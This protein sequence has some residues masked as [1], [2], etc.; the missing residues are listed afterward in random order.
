MLDINYLDYSED[1]FAEVIED[2]PA[3]IYVFSDYNNKLQAEKIY[4]NPALKPGSQF[5]TMIELKEKLF[6]TDRLVLKEEKLS[7]IFYELLTAQEKEILSVDDYFD[8]IDLAGDFFHFYD[9]L[10]EYNVEDIKGLKKWQLKKYEIF[11]GLRQRYIKY[12]EKKGFS[13]R[14]LNFCMKNFNPYYLDNYEEVVFVNIVNF[15]PAEKQMLVAVE[16]SGKVVRLYLQLSP[17]DFD[18]QELRVKSVTLPDELNNIEIL[19]TSEKLLQL[20][21]VLA[22][23][24]GEQSCILDADFAQSSYQR[25]LSSSEMEVSTET[26]FTQTTIFKFLNYHYLLL[27]NAE[28]TEGRLKLRMEDLIKFCSRKEFRN[29]Y[30]IEKEEFTRLLQLAAEDYVYFDKSLADRGLKNIVLLLGEV[31]KI[32]GLKSLSDFCTYLENLNF[33]ILNDRK[34]KDNIVQ[35]FDALAELKALDDMQLVSS[36]VNYFS[37]RA[38]GFFQLIINYLKYKKVKKVTDEERKMIKIEDLNCAAHRKHDR[39][40]I[41]NAN[42]DTLPSLPAKD[43]LLSESQREKLGLPL[44]RDRRIE[45]KYYFCRHLFNS[46]RVVICYLDNL[47][48]DKTASPFVEELKLEY[49]LKSK[50]M[51]IK[52]GNYPQVI[53]SIFSPERKWGNTVEKENQE[54]DILKIESTDFPENGF[55]LSFYKYRVL[56][57]CYYRFYLEHI[58]GL[59]EKWVVFEKKLSPRVLGN[60]VHEMFEEI[61]GELRA[62]T[63]EYG[64]KTDNEVIKEIVYKKMSKYELKIP[65]YYLSY[66]EK[67][68]IPHIVQS[69]IAFFEKIKKKTQGEVEKVLTEWSP[70]VFK[71]FFVHK[72]SNFYL[73]GRIDL[74]IETGTEKHI[75]DFKT[76][77]RDS[78]QLDFYW[79]LWQ[80]SVQNNEKIQKYFYSVMEQTLEPTFSDPRK[81]RE[82]LWGELEVFTGSDEYSAE[83]KS[84]CKN[85]NYRDICRMVIK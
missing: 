22:K 67:I 42:S 76:G 7:V 68:M 28:N 12:M 83:Y 30:Q 63:A 2:S 19:Y 16:G 9:E 74:I 66:Y 50:N 29:Y 1:L 11:K 75:I 82:K 59:E 48:E 65:A 4:K 64:F 70:Q 24:D 79:L 26:D 41:F 43:F 52:E 15:T 80:Q 8:V 23:T 56:K 77:G 44:N 54:Q 20:V 3:K 34:L 21:N 53:K 36:W 35:F 81:F 33:E 58:E 71:D 37:N 32:N 39:L 38:R 61:I 57:D 60:I 18:E 10:N 6:P 27:Q 14:T 84:R 69:I 62:D 73:S 31:E 5:L 17:R 46:E 72:K 49:G 85:C 45:Q 51:E 40:F 78:E 47:E 55:P 13:D 25:L